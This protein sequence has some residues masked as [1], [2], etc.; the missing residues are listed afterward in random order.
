MFATFAFQRGTRAFPSLLFRYRV[1]RIACARIILQKGRGGEVL[2]LHW[3]FTLAVKRHKYKQM[4]NN[5]RSARV[6]MSFH[7]VPLALSSTERLK[8]ASTSSA[9]HR[10]YAILPRADF[11]SA[12][13]AE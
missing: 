4:L 3:R 13:P 9:S 7:L 6:K 12:H 1:S 11:Q 2:V 8:T 5:G 10:Y